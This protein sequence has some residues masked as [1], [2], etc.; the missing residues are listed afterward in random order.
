MAHKRIATLLSIGLILASCSGSSSNT[1]DDASQGP[2]T[3]SAQAEV[4]S[5]VEEEVPATAEATPDSTTTVAPEPAAPAPD[6]PP[7]SELP[8]EVQEPTKLIALRAQPDVEN[9]GI[10]VDALGREVL[11]R[12]VNVNS[13][14]EYWEG[15]EFPATRP[16]TEDDADGIAAM[17]WNMVRLLFTW[18]RVE[19]EP[20]VYD[21]A[22]LDELEAAV[23]MLEARGIYTV[24]D[25]HQDAWGPTLAA[26]PGEVCGEGEEPANGW[27]GAPGWA[28]LVA[29]E[30][31]RCTPAGIRELSPAVREAAGAFFA[32]AEGPGGVGIRT[33]YAQMWG[34][35]AARFA[36]DAAVAGFDLINE[37]NTFTAEE[38]A[39]LAALYSEASSEI[40]AAEAAAD[41]VSHILMF[42]PWALWSSIGNSDGAELPEWDRDDNVAYAPHLYQGAFDEADLTSEWFDNAVAEAAR[43]GGAPIY[44]GEWGA[45]IGV[46]RGGAARVGE[47]SSEYFVEHQ[48]LQDD[49]H[50]SAALW[51]W[52]ESCGDPHNVPLSESPRIAGLWE[53]DCSTNTQTSYRTELA[54]DL[55]RPFPHAAPGRIGSLFYD[56]A[57]GSLAVTAVDAPLDTEVVVF[58]PSG[59]HPDPETSGSGLSDIEIAEG[60]G[61]SIMIT[62]TTTA[63]TWSL[64]VG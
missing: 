34:H 31:P 8:P 20:G 40:R 2:S 47:G 27:D 14:G 38:V 56:D 24:L 15:N 30:T 36:N 6:D 55:L 58:Y 21:E 32:N 46:T 48:R 28:T 18:S 42:E 23:R 59:K 60:P 64:D 22:Y 19:P 11:L 50:V 39:G 44:S 26:R 62:A 10:I 35:V 29:D 5:A 45:A 41:G 12:G 54:D 61:D 25:S 13:Y 49:Y 63:T 4:E 57:T 9:G 7:T 52:H 17:G 1:A 53:V 3:S 33:R 37:P 51:M 16:F 43:F